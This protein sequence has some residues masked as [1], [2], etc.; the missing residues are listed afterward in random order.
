MRLF[1]LLRLI[2]L[3]YILEERTI[4]KKGLGAT[5]S[6]AMK[7]NEPVVPTEAEVMMAG[8]ASRKLAALNIRDEVHVVFDDNKSMG[9]VLPASIVRM[10][11]H[12]LTE[13]AQGNAVNVAPINAEMTTQ[14]AADFLNVSRP[15]VVKQMEAGIL[16]YHKVGTH[17]RIHFRDLLA[18]KKEIDRRRDKNLSE[19]TAEA[20]RLGIG[21]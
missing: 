20:Q 5:M 11:Q 7:V 12:I 4:Y 1:H 16:P 2:R 9:M 14:E 8:E 18:Y 3:S 21:Y 6:Y 17:R 10:F 15:F 19:L 13:T